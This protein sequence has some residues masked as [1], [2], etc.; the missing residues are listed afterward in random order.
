MDSKKLSELKQIFADGPRAPVGTY[1]W[2]NYFQDQLVGWKAAPI[3]FTAFSMFA[4]AQSAIGFTLSEFMKTVLDGYNGVVGVLTWP[5]RELV[6]PVIVFI[7][8]TFKL[9]IDLGVGW[10]HAL[11]ILAMYFLIDLRV[12]YLRRRSA[13]VATLS[14]AAIGM[15][16]AMVASTSSVVFAAL[17]QPLLSAMS[18][19]LGFALYEMFKAPI[20][21]KYM[22]VQGMTYWASALYFFSF[23]GVGNAILAIVSLMVFLAL[24]FSANAGA[25]LLVLIIFIVLVALRNIVM[26]FSRAYVFERRRHANR[27]GAMLISGSMQVAGSLMLALLATA[28]LV[29]MNAAS[30]VASG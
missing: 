25:E 6:E 14:T 11:F 22:P 1:S 29:V 30:K 26:A 20:T 8:S 4:L 18:P 15:V 13:L 9:E 10:R 21:A 19:P 23:Y 2:A 17:S 27:T 24:P 16:I 5:L 7:A 3:F 28:G 12:G